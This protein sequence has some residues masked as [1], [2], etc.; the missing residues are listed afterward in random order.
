MKVTAS[1]VKAKTT[2][3]ETPVVAFGRRLIEETVDEGVLVRMTSVT[4]RA[5]GARR[6]TRAGA[7]IAAVTALLGGLLTVSVAAPATAATSTVAQ[8]TPA[9]P[10]TPATAA[11]TAEATS[12]TVTYD[13]SSLVID[14][15]RT[16]IWSGEFHYWRLPNVTMWRD[17][18]QKLKAEGYNAVSIYFDWQYHSPK[19]G[20]Y[21]FTGVR[22]VDQLLD[23]AQEVGLYVIARPGPY[24][25]AETNAGGYPLWLTN[26]AGKARTNDATYIAASDEWLTKIDAILKNHL[27][28]NGT[29]TVI[30]YQIENELATT[31]TTQQQ[32]MQ[33]L[34]DKVRADGIDVPIFH[35]DKGRNGIWVPSGSGVSGTVTGPNDMY[36]FDSY[37]GG[38]CSSNGSPGSP[39]V[40]PDY[41]FYGSG[42][43]TGGAT[44]SPNTPGFLA[45]F[46]GGW[47]DYWGSKGTYECTSVREGSGYERVFYETN[48]A[49]GISLQNFYMTYGGTSWG[50]LP[51]PVVYTSYDYGSAI[52]EARQIRD[53]ASTMKELGFFLQSVDPITKQQKSTTVTPSSSLVKVYNNVNPDTGTHFYTAMH[54]PSSA[55][56]NDTFTFPLTTADGTYTVP[57]SGTLRLNGQDSKLLVADYDMDGQHLVYSTSEI[58]THLTRG[59]SDLALLYGR[60]GETGETVLRYASQPTVTVLSGDVTST[61]DAATGDLRLNYTHDGLAK[62]QITGG[63]RTPLLLLLADT[64]T[65]DTFWVQD[66]SSGKV[67]ERG[68]ELVRTAAV[69]G[70]TLALTGDTDD[71][72]DLEVWAPTGVTS[73]TWNGSAKTTSVEN[74][75]ALTT[76][77]QLAGAPA[78]TLPDLTTA[79]W[80]YS[81]ESPE[82]Q[83]T[84]DDSTWTVASKTTT[85]STTP[86]PSGSVVLTEDDYGFHQGDVWYRGSYTANANAA[87]IKLQYGGGGAG[88]LQAW[89]DGVYLGQNVIP[90]GVSAPATTATASFTIP[91]SLRSGSHVISVMVRNDGHNEDGGVNDAQK[92]G[93]GLI[94]VTTYNAAATAVATPITWKIQGNTGG[95][96]VVDTVRGA[97]NVGGLY[98]ER[99]GWYLPG[100]PDSSWTKTTLPATT[101]TAGTSWYRTQFDLDIP[102]DVDA[103]LGLTIGDPSKPQADGHYRALI[104]VN[105]WNIGQYIADVGPQKTFVI[106]SGVI[107]PSGHNTVAIAVTSNGG[108]GDGLEKVVLT[109][110]G[111]VRGGTPLVVNDAPSWDAAT[112]G[113]PQAVSELVAAPLTSDAAEGVTKPNKSVVVTQ[114]VTNPSTAAVSGV[115]ATLT[116]PTGWTVTSTTSDPA[117]TIPAGGTATYTWKVKVS[118][119]AGPGDVALASQVTYGSGETAG[120]TGSTLPLTIK[121][122]GEIAL[123]SLP[124]KSSTLAY[125]SIGVNTN[126]AGAPITINGVVYTSGIGVNSIATINYDIPAGCTSFTTLVGMDQAATAGKGSVTFELRVDGVAKATSAKISG[127]V[128]PAA[129]LGPIDVTGGQVLTLYVGDAGDGNGHDNADFAN[130]TFTCTPDV[131]PPV[132]TVSLP[133]ANASGWYTTAPSATITA[134]DDISGVDSIEYRLGTSGD[135]TTYTAPVALTDAD[136]VIQA[137]AT[138]K[139]ENTTDDDDLVTRQVKIDTVAPEVSGTI[140]GDR[141]L[142]VT[143]DDAHLSSVEYS[144]DGNAWAPYTAPVQL[145]DAELTVSLRAKDEAGNTGTGSVHVDAVPVPDTTAP[146]VS[147]TLPEA[148]AAGWF[149]S[150]P[151]LT[152]QASDADSGVDTVEYRL[153]SSGSW[154]AYTGAVALSDAVSVVQARATDKAGN[155]S[156]VVSRT[157]H[158]DTQ[159]PVVSGSVSADR[160]L[161]VDAADAHLAGVQYSLDAV[162]WADYTAPVQLGG[163]A[164]TVSLRATD[165]AGNTGTG[166]VEVG[167]KPLTAT[168]TALALAGAGTTGSALV[169]TASVVP[170]DAT[171]TVEFLDGSAV[172]GQ[173]PLAGGQATFTVAAVTE[174]AHAF[175]ARFTGADGAYLAGSTSA[176][177]PL[178]SQKN[179]AS[180]SVTVPAH[181]Y[182]AAS[183][184]KVTVTSAGHP[185]TGTVTV[186]V[187]GVLRTLTLTGGAATTAVPATLATGRQDVYVL[188]L[189]NATTNAAVGAA[190]FTVSKA[191]ST[192][193]L[194]L[195]AKKATVKKTKVK[196]T[197][198]VKVP[199]TSITPAGTVTVK[200]GKKVLKTFTLKGSTKTVKLP[201]FRTTGTKKI[202]ATFSG[203]ANVKA[204][205]STA[206]KI[207]VTK[208]KH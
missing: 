45:E 129:T 121:A 1:K 195:S 60:D 201:A 124:V 193:T 50:W 41:G 47:F 141:V 119:S 111:T 30:L 86:P 163:A 186:A 35:N 198:T 109:D 190:S 100:F 184:A 72:A 113:A 170:G 136:T 192:V 2:D 58:M 23:I 39:S 53:K 207:K 101:A 149:T 128:T 117:T 103:S 158:V 59:T 180:V 5:G 4:R 173:A 118:A 43:A 12:H 98:G 11:S 178:T 194:K 156:D 97:N 140:S 8:T 65:A 157:V 34:Y 126:L 185:A 182:G 31:G 167:E 76:T 77:A 14:G 176:V 26:V 152:V 125:G 161:T 85:T 75:G 84:F 37:P 145:G 189:G 203:D 19:Q 134:T 137:R 87:T 110:L 143:A 25:N 89:I 165:E 204:R 71:A 78:V 206:A 131:T 199:G 115:A 175:S 82:A 104:Y 69:S 208:K 132:V 144:F 13:S 147:I 6:G 68:P 10:A 127:I 107:D 7:A 73:V 200:A 49:N 123:S 205:T 74:D 29:G 18:L 183:T 94:A 48:V 142:T 16:Y 88:M 112:Y 138:D 61:Y 83:K 188:Y 153:G 91:E 20:V 169:L 116:A 102:S 114:T 95:E 172:I 196:A 46:G 166:A 150:V 51:A 106:P 139:E 146:A 63:G 24:V 191:T 154:T 81:A 28:T 130:P 155:V 148:N 54:N 40:A 67:L 181:T 17:V 90:S 56:S 93:R 79:Q 164:V 197:V 62:V 38:T 151:S 21:D 187:G 171:G 168:S 64:S 105:G 33:H 57:Q 27:L 96:D 160:V 122:A 32:Y 15:K 202:K 133:D 99:A 3:F 70:S 179:A 42:G 159:V 66:T 9:T 44:A 80:S 108:A 36:A 92:E 135:W 52:S 120:T 177:V 174:G 55:T 22:D 162:A